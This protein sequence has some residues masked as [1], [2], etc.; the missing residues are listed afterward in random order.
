[1][2]NEILRRNK[3]LSNIRLDQNFPEIRL[4][5]PNAIPACSYFA[6]ESHKFNN[7]AKLTLIK[8]ITNNRSKPIEVIWDILLKL[9][10]FWF[11]KEHK[12]VFSE[13]PI[14]G[15]R[16]GKSLKNYLVRAALTK[17]DNAGG[18]EPCEKDTCQVCNH[19]ITTNTF[20]T[21]HVGKYLK[22]KVGPLTVT[23]K[24]FFTFLDAKFVMI[25]PMLEKLKQ[26]FAFGLI[27]IK[28]NTD[29]FEKENRMYHRTVFI[30]TIFKIDTEVLMIG[31]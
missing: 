5:D 23:Q 19:I 2:Q 28:V 26:S 8:T 9:K 14:V 17:M 10:I 1:M 7:H 24:R 27:I 20:T 18:S 25:L 31:K 15:F 22:F 13:V 11:N 29:L 12:K 16:N 4:S 3:K 21:K 30:H 6:Q